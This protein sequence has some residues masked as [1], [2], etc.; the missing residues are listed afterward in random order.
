MYYPLTAGASPSAGPQKCFD[1]NTD[2][3]RYGNC[4][5]NSVNFIQ[6]GTA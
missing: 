4:G 6:C 3:D 2:G 5:H 1:V